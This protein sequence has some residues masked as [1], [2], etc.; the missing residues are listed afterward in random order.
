[1]KQNITIEQLKELS[2]DGNQKLLKW[3]KW[4]KNDLCYF[5]DT[6][7]VGMWSGSPQGGTVYPLLS[8]GQM[9]EF[10]FDHLEQP[11][12]LYFNDMQHLGLDDVPLD[13]LCDA[14]WEA[15]KEILNKS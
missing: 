8:I 10:L 1:M 13:N 14:L 2:R 6:Q 9:I 12:R 15:V 4:S 7:H 3:W 5:T 11:K